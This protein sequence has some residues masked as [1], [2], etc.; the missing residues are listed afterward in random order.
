MSALSQLALND[1]GFIFDPT[2]GDSYQANGTALA[3]I[4]ALRDGAT[5]TEAAQTLADTYAVS[6]EEA[7]RDVG[8]FAAFLAQ[9]GWE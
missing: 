3:V 5:E 1:E 7:G 8:D 2:T 4:T 6:A 9:F